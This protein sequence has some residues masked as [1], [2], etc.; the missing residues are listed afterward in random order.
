MAAAGG[1][2]HVVPAQVSAPRRAPLWPHGPLRYLPARNP[3]SVYAC[4]AI[5][6]RVQFAIYLRLH[7]AISQPSSTGSPLALWCPP[8]SAYVFLFFL[9]RVHSAICLCVLRY[10][11]TLAVRYLPRRGFRHLP[12]RFPLSAYARNLLSA[13][14][15]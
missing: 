5:C 10:L 14:A 2:E 1:E 11:S 6:L 7:S 4:S 12:T 9:L 15:W 3:L 8:L 13:Y